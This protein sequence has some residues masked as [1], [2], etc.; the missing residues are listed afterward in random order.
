MVVLTER[1][2]NK[3]REVLAQR[4]QQPESTGLRLFVQQGGCS[5]YAYGLKFDS[6]PGAN[7][8]TVEQH[9][10]RVFVDKDSAPLLQGT[11]IDYVEELTGGGFT[12]ENPNAVQ[13]CG[14]G[15]S[16]RTSQHRGQPQPCDD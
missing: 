16:F 7:D 4:R 12:I 13:A 14:C 5:G 9:G 1:A 11:K 3:I 10:I 2:S 6:N 8:H 15:Q